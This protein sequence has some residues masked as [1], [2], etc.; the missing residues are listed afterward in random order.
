MKTGPEFSSNRGL[1]LMKTGPEFSSNRGL[2][3]Q[4][5]GNFTRGAMPTIR[6]LVFLGCQKCNHFLSKYK[7]DNNEKHLKPETG[8]LKLRQVLKVFANLRPAY[9][10]LQMLILYFYLILLVDTST[11]KKEVAE[12][13]DLMVVR[14]LTGGI[15]ALEK[16]S[17]DNSLRV[18]IIFSK[19]FSVLID[20]SLFVANSKHIEKI[21]CHIAQT[22]KKKLQFDTIVTINIFGDILSDEVSMIMGIIGMLP[23]ASLGK[24]GPGLFEPI[25][26]SAPDIAGQ[27]K[28]KLAN[29]LATILSAAMLLKY[30]LGEVKAAQRIENFVRAT[31]TP[32][33]ITLLDARRW[34]ERW[35]SL[36]FRSHVN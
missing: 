30:G 35:F 9:V 33:E 20:V 11:L 10:L 28:A 29:P 2:T 16:K 18:C 17:N 8:L 32:K 26:G 6:D 7:W 25:H 21:G 12:G 4:I 23:S 27:D 31:Y 3:F 5:K 22:K 13:V 24:E 36:C 34:A 19:L 14:E 1:S 15:N